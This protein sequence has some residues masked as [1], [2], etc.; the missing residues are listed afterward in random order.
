MSDS[1][2]IVVEF[3]EADSDGVMVKSVG[4]G[5]G[6]AVVGNGVGS[7]VGRGVGSGVSFI[8]GECDGDDVTSFVVLG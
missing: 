6:S 7:T 8:D 2:I 5:V 1:S 4:C 3:D